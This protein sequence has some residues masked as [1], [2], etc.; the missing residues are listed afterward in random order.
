MYILNTSRLCSY[1]IIKFLTKCRLDGQTAL[2]QGC[3]YECTRYSMNTWKHSCQI[4]ALLTLILQK[5]ETF[6]PR[7]TLTPRH[8]TWWSLLH[9]KWFN[10]T[11]LKIASKP[12]IFWPYLIATTEVT[13]FSCLPCWS[14]YW[15]PPSSNAC[16]WLIKHKSD[17]CCFSLK[18]K[19]ITCHTI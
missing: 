16:L 15:S 13:A 8:T 10:S 5:K 17:R 6:K 18:F 2:L 14:I 3:C 7:W 9:L 4:N 1:G 11:Y 12:I 19:A